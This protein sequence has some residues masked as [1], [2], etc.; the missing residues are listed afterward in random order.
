[1]YYD[2]EKL[3]NGEMNGLIL[4]RNQLDL[5]FWGPKFPQN[6]VRIATLEG[7]TDRERR[8]FYINVSHTMGDIANSTIRDG[9]ASSFV[10]HDPH[11]P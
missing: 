2:G 7:V 6:R 8:Q 5:P 11:D 9:F 4:T 1:M 10:T 3:K